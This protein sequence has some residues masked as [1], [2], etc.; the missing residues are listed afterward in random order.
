MSA[1]VVVG[2]SKLEI[3]PLLTIGKAS[4]VLG[5]EFIGMA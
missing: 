1:G 2:R 3:E 5:S 4:S